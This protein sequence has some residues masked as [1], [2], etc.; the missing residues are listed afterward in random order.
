MQH[1]FKSP[2]N[3]KFLMNQGV[4][5]TCLI[6]LLLLFASGR[7]LAGPV[8]A[9]VAGKVA[10]QFYKTRNIPAWNS[11]AYQV[12]E[13]QTIQQ[14]NTNGEVVAVLYIFELS[15]E[16]GSILVAADDRISPVLGYTLKSLEGT[17]VHPPQFEGLLMHYVRNITRVIESAAEASPEVKAAWKKLLSEN[18]HSKSTLAVGP[19]VTTTWDQ[20]EF[21]NDSCPADPNAWFNGRVPTGCVATT[22][23]QI[24]KYHA[25]PAAG[26]GFHTFHHVDYGDLSANFGGT[27]Y[28]WSSMPSSL[29]FSNTAVAQ[30]MF[31]C[32]VAVEMNYGPYASGAPSSNAAEGLIHYFNYST[33]THLVQRENYTDTD[34]IALLKNEIDQNRVCYYAGYGTAGH[35][36]VMD[37]Y[38]DNNFL[39]FNWGWSGWYD[40]FFDINS[41]DPGGNQFNDYQE[42]IIGIQPGVSTVCNGQTTLTEP[43]GNFTDGSYSSNYG[44]NASCSW[45]I[46]PANN[47]QSIELSFVTFRTEPGADLVKVYDGNSN[48]APLL[49]T[50]S[51]NTLPPVLESTGPEMFV[52]FITN[53]S[54]T[55]QGWSAHY[56][57]KYCQPTETLNTGSGTLSDGSGIY[58][59]RNNTQCQWLID[60]PLADMIRL[61]FTA[62]DTEYDFDFVDVYDGATTNDPLLGHFSGD[63]LPP[64]LF[65]TGTQLLVTFS[66]DAGVTL[67][68]WEADWVSFVV[69]IDGKEDPTGMAI[70]PNPATDQ[71]YLVL[72]NNMALQQLSAEILDITGRVVGRTLAV[73]QGNHYQVDVKS[74]SPG[75]YLL[76]CNDTQGLSHQAGFIKK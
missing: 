40:G 76:K 68:G 4:F 35:A 30:L 8:T 67:Q 47:P 24:L 25:Y 55:Q 41:L 69:G 18:P 73:Q 46:Q 3:S 74:L 5:R 2:F 13:V 20:G 39:H 64:V 59:Y 14:T 6:S 48:T 51:G 28:N 54:V 65:S 12:S 23:A 11:Q 38:D 37:G 9:E 58:A 19:L 62:F 16:R 7:M 63:T 44:N 15:G 22:M 56:E 72:D 49:G 53:G 60:F 17:K 57:I 75:Y 10:E 45:L 52:E 26:A 1:R 27:T 61:T 34:W 43:D 21:Y 32:G 71:V 42:A 50:F 33:T 31:H 36:F 66:S 29:S 70:F